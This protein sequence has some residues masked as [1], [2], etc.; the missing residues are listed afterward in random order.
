M[1]VGCNEVQSASVDVDK[2][3][4]RMLKMLDYWSSKTN[5]K[6]RYSR[7]NGLFDK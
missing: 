4:K 2:N 7:K 1:S 3:A 5:I 6:N